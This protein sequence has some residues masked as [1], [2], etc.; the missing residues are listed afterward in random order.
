MARVIMDRDYISCIY[1]KIGTRMRIVL[2][3]NY[4]I[5][6]TCVYLVLVYELCV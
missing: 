6:K 4:G 2:Q 3:L 5:T 1:I